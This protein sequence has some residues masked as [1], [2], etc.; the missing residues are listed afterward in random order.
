ML[1]V[2]VVDEG[3]G[4][5]RRL[6]TDATGVFADRGAANWLL[7]SCDSDATA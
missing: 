6:M 1:R 7:H 5:Q 3:T 4:A 2:T